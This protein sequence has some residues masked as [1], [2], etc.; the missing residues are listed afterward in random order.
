ML[1]G[2]GYQAYA[3]ENGNELYTVALLGDYDVLLCDL[4]LIEINGLECAQKLRQAGVDVHIIAMT[5]SS[6]EVSRADCLD[7]GMDDYLTK[8]VCLEDLKRALHVAS[9][10]RQTKTT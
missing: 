2:L 10:D 1:R 5:G 3:C 6:P 8:P 9:L 4:D 7:A